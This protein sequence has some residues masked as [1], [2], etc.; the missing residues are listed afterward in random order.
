LS[1]IN[2]IGSAFYGCSD[3]GSDGSYVT[4]K[5]ITILI[6][7]VPVGSYRVR[8]ISSTNLIVYSSTEYESQT[9]PLHWPHI[10]AMYA[11]YFAAV[12]FFQ[13]TDLLSGPKFSHKVSN[14]FLAAFVAVVL[15]VIALGISRFIR[16]G[17]IFA[18]LIVIALILMFSF[19]V[20]G[21]ISGKP[22]ATLQY[23]YYLWGA[24]VAYTLYSF[25]NNGGKTDK[26]TQSKG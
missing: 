20:A 19:M 18:N 17:R 16:R 5:W 12:V 4:T 1:T 14:P 11:T 21:N 9:V 13:L 6:P 22:E 8:P 2:G 24:Y 15:S 10:V 23:M 3:V 7:L 25:V 26:D